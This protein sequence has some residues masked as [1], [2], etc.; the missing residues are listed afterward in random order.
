MPRGNIVI[1]AWIDGESA[2]CVVYRYGNSPKTL[3]I[4]VTVDGDPMQPAADDPVQFGQEVATGDIGE[5]LG[6]VAR[7]LRPDPAG[8]HW[9]GYLDEQLPVKGVEEPRPRPDRDL[10]ESILAEMRAFD[11]WVSV[12]DVLKVMGT[13]SFVADR[14]DVRAVLDCVDASERLRLGRVGERFEEIGKPIPVAALVDRIFAENGPADR[15]AAMME[16][17]IDD[18]GDVWGAPDP[19]R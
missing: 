11:D 19:G 1:D 10:Q 8:I 14:A 16:L 4:R 6:T 17:F 18:T 5:P 3:G 2:F 7:N 12:A 9:W 13:T 15:S